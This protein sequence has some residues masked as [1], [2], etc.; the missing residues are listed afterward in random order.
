MSVNSARQVSRQSTS[1][2]TLWGKNV[3]R[4]LYKGAPVENQ[5]LP[6]LTTCIFLHSALL[7]KDRNENLARLRRLKK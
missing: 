4:L 1:F 6:C 3:G 2:A 5:K 7:S